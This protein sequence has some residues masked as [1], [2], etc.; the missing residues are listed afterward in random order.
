LDRRVMMERLQAEIEK[1]TAR[2]VEEAR[3]QQAYRGQG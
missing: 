1:A 3:A 2:L